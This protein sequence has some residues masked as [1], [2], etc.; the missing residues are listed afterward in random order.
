MSTVQVEF[1]FLAELDKLIE[2]YLSEG[3]SKGAI[4]DLMHIA[5]DD[6]FDCDDVESGE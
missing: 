1:D 5:I 6:M 4:E 3:V 2:K